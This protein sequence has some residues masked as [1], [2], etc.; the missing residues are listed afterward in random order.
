D[1]STLWLGERDAVYCLVRQG[2]LPARFTP[3]AQLALEPYLV[4]TAD[5]RVAVRVGGQEHVIATEPKTPQK[6]PQTG[7]AE[8]GAG[9]ANA[10]AGA[11]DPGSGAPPQA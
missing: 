1:A 4:L 5:G 2:R 11:M 9:A 7:L 8:G 6:N 10:D 3:G